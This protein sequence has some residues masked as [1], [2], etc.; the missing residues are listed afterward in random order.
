VLSIDSQ[1][2]KDFIDVHVDCFLQRSLVVV[3]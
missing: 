3:V 2:L 1:K